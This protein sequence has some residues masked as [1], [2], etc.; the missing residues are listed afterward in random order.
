MKDLMKI[1]VSLLFVVM[2][3]SCQNDENT[4]QLEM[5]D[6]VVNDDLSIIKSLGFDENSAVDK[7]DFYIVE[8]DIIISKANLA[9]YAEKFKDEGQLKHGR[10]PY[11]VSV[12]NISDLTIMLDRSL[13]GSN[14]NEALRYTIQ[15]Y[16]ETGSAIRMREVSNNADIVLRAGNIGAYVCG[17]GGFPTSD[18]RAYPEVLLNTSFNNRLSLSQ[19]VLLVAHELGH[20][21]G[22]RHTNW[23]GAGEGGGIHIPGTP[24]GADPDPNSVFQGSTCGYD[25]NGFSYYDL[26]AIRTLY[27]SGGSSYP[28]YPYGY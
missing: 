18:G 3:S 26:V 23:Q 19:K 15:A 8:E 24:Q 16:N 11:I 14:W 20:N 1:L 22:F 7:G 28:N 9:G 17:Q 21:I 6:I 4:D 25:W 5:P 2:L 10:S 13:S 27:P 12:N